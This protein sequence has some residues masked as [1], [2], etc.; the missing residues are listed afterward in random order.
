MALI[1]HLRR[2]G[3]RLQSW[4]RRLLG[5]SCRKPVVNDGSVG[6]S[7]LDSSEESVSLGPLETWLK[8]PSA[9]QLRAQRYSLK[10]LPALLRTSAI[11]S[12]KA[13]AT[14]AL[15]RHET[16]DSNTV[17]HQ[18]SNSDG[19]ASKGGL[20]RIHLKGLRFFGYHGVYR[21]E[22]TLGQ[23]FILDLVMHVADLRKA[24]STDDLSATVDYSG[25]YMDVKRI[26]E[27]QP[28]QLLEALAQDVCKTIFATQPLVEKVDLVIKKPHV[29][30][31]GVIDYSG[32]EVTRT[33]DDYMTY[34]SYLEAD[35]GPAKPVV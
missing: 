21:E 10:W 25:V 12:C 5:V 1:R 16:I 2:A 19:T 22:T 34:P 24:G 11:Q 27:G 29:A 26:M 8:V 3:R 4:Y 9:M 18:S 31:P 35:T 13:S 14:L 20:D 6:R 17:R 30:L 33:R 32:V 23:L 15:K 28:R 7:E